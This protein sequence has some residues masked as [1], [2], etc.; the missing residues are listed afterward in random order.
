MTLLIALLV[1]VSW[2]D[3]QEVVS[4]VQRIDQMR[5]TMVQAVTPPI[6]AQTFKAVCAPVGK[7]ANRVAVQRMG[8]STSL[9]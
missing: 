9:E 6:T 2:A 8:V 5:K 1:S 3:T 4:E 7:E